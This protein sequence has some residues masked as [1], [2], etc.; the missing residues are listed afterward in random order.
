MMASAG[1][2]K[3]FTLLETL[4]AIT[5]LAFLTLG[6]TAALRLGLAFP[7]AAQSLDRIG[8]VAAVQ[9]FLRRELSS[10]LALPAADWEGVA[11]LGSPS[12]FEMIGA[13]PER[14]AAGGLHEVRLSLEG[15]RLMLRWRRLDPPGPAQ[16]RALLDH[17]SGL[18]IAYWGS[19]QDAEAAAWHGDWRAA[20]YLPALVRIRAQL[21]GAPWPELIVALPT[22]PE[23]LRP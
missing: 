11:F 18:D 20:Q 9:N 22:Q 21:A 8:P 16:Q 17:V 15:D 2:N 10:A 14:A 5:L 7:G 23:E 6:L 1:G 13:M 4:I 12:A 3:G 19:R